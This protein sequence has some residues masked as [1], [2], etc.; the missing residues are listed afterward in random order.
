M[1]ATRSFGVDMSHQHHPLIYIRS[2]GRNRS[3]YFREAPVASGG[4]NGTYVFERRVVEAGSLPSHTFDEHMLMLPLGTR[5]VRF[6]SVLNGCAIKGLIEPGRFRFLARGDTLSTAWNGPLDTL[7]LALTPALFGKV[8]DE[9]ID[10]SG[11]DL[12]SNISPHEDRALAH[13]LQLIQGCAEGRN[14][15]GRL[16]EHSL[17]TAI[18]AHILVRYGSGRRR[19]PPGPSL[20]RWKF[21]RLRDFIQEHLGQDLGLS[22]LAAVVDLSPWHL[23]RAFRATTGRSLWQYVLECRVK[24]AQR[25]M[26]AQPALLLST[27]ADICGFRSYSQFIAVFRIHCGQLPSEFRRTLKQR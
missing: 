26:T 6:R 10:A 9:T 16:F 15:A 12:L 2:D 21:L 1:A 22:D 13:L 8:V 20:P 25:L 3:P 7:F 14:I 24:A 11:W 18:A 27:V 23:G 19:L 4:K 17:L 5:A